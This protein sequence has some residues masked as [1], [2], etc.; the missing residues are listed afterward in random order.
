MPLLPLVLSTG[1]LLN[2][3]AGYILVVIGYVSRRAVKLGVKVVNLRGLPRNCI[4]RLN[5]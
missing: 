3:V 4:T 2:A 1:W 5:S